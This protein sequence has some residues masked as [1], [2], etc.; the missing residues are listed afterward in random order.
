MEPILLSEYRQLPSL[1]VPYLIHRLVPENGRILLL[2]P[3]KAGKSF[4]ALQAGLHVAQGRPFIG[5][6]TKQARVLYLQ[7]D[8][9]DHLWKERLDDLSYNGVDLGGEFFMPKPTAIKQTFDIISPTNQTAMITA[10]VKI[11]P[12]LVIIDV[13]S[14]L[15][16]LDGNTEKDMKRVWNCLNEI[17]A[18][19]ALMVVHH[20]PKSGE[21]KEGKASGFI[22][23]PSTAARGSGYISGE[24]DANWLLWP[25]GDQQCLFWVESRFDEDVKLTA[26]RNPE[27]TLWTF[28]E[29]AE[30]RDVSEKLI[31]LCDEFP[32]QSHGQLAPLAM[33]RFG[34]SRASY[35]R[36]MTGLKCRHFPVLLATSP[37]SVAS[38]V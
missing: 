31:A 5:R 19:R 17:F 22:P 9:P 21:D 7:F 14:K 18:G 8:T 30:I 20:T 36:R 2:G 32:G 26:I 13:Y 27:T 10:L 33:K 16:H 15:H 35:Y 3:P 38:D 6:A 34:L 25:T 12:Q 28:P 24:V 11:N 37:E 4:F 1:S 23:R 29:E